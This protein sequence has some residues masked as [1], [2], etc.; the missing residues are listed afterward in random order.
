MIF[1]LKYLRDL[2]YSDLFKIVTGK[3]KRRWKIGMTCACPTESRKKVWEI[4][5]DNEEWTNEMIQMQTS[6]YCSVKRD[7]S[8]VG[9]WEKSK[10]SRE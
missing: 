6:E 8:S 2:I 7:T 10:L 1:Q 5:N 3:I 9:A 4:S